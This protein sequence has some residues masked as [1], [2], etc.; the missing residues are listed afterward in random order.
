MGSSE[1]KPAIPAEKQREDVVKHNRISDLFD[2]RSP[3]VGI[4]RTPIQF[5]CPGAKPSAGVRNECPVAFA[6]PRSPSI[7]ISRTPVRDAMRATVGSLARRLGL[8]FNAE[9]EYPVSEG[10][11]VEEE[12][13]LFKEELDSTEPLLTPQVR[14]SFGSMGEHAKLLATPVQPPVHT[15]G[16]SSPYI[17]LEEPQ[18]EVEIESELGVEDAEEA[19]ESPLHNRLSMSLITCHEGAPAFQIFAEVHADVPAAPNVEVQNDAEH[20]YAIPTITVEPN[21]SFEPSVESTEPNS[22]TLPKMTAQ[23]E[24]AEE[25]KEEPDMAITCEPTSCSSPQQ[26]PICTP[27]LTLDPKSPSQAVFKPQWLG[28]GFGATGLRARTIQGNS[29]KR[30]SSPLAKSVAVRNVTNENKGVTGKLKQ[31]GNEGRSPLQILKGTNSPRDHQQVKLKVSTPERQR[32]GQMDRRVLAL[33]L[34][35]ENR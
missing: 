32:L 35:K 18:V 34:D 8:F 6:D 12:K 30:A 20:S 1:S 33:G 21:S 9:M 10:K 27:C 14:Q 16:Q 24:L 2:P 5:N 29:G 4:D 13:V 22:P 31:R 15:L 11:S 7:G 25:T 3:S 26:Q 28:K 17:L 19:I 23:L